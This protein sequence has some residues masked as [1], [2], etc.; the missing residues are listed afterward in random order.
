[1]LFPFYFPVFSISRENFRNLGQPLIGDFLYNPENRI[2][3]RQALHAYRL[4]FT[5]PVTGVFIDLK[6][7][8]A[9]DMAA[10]FP[11]FSAF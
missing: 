11:D 1:M 7:L 2:I 9:A 10:V 5:Y 6:A 8:P 3:K 4:Q